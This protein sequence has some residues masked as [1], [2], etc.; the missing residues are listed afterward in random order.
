MIKKTKKT[1]LTS[2]LQ[3]TKSV[4]NSRKTANL[5]TEFQQFSLTPM[6]L[7]RRKKK[8][9]SRLGCPSS[10]Q[11]KGVDKLCTSSLKLYLSQ[12]PKLSVNQKFPN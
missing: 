7:R 8:S 11:S 6:I 2:F 5:R 1:S 9:I 10:A 12:V 3:Q 4:A